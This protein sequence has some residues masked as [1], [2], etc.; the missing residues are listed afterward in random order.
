MKKAKTIIK[1][2]DAPAV[3]SS[4]S[5][6]NLCSGGDVRRA[7]AR[8]APRNRQDLSALQPAVVAHCVRNVA[9]PLEL[10]GTPRAQ[11]EATVL[12]LL[13]L[14]GLSA[15]KDRY[16]SQI[17]GGQKQR[18]GIAR[19]LASQ[20]KVLLSDEA[21]SALDPETT[22]AIRHANAGTSRAVAG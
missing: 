14:V 13:E 7:A 8:C 21:T 12:P 6:P 4:S 17:G 15:Q 5:N 9:P 1:G 19:A 18:V 2:Y 16:P 10:A 3:R 22:R 20:P 11:I